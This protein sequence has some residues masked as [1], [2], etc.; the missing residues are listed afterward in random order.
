[1]TRCGVPDCCPSHVMPLRRLLLLSALWPACPSEKWD[2]R[3][4]VWPTQGDILE[5]SH[6]L[7]TAGPSLQNCLPQAEEP[8][9]PQVPQKQVK[10]TRPYIYKGDHASLAR[11]LLSPSRMTGITD[12]DQD[13]HFTSQTTECWALVR[14]NHLS[15]MAPIGPKQ[16]V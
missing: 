11:M 10:V 5:A 6:S 3:N 4:T 9:V 15:S 7:S 12:S 8:L 13:T 14:G 16:L 1:M 2:L